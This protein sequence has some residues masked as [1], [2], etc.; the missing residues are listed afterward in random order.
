[1]YFR[2]SFDC[3]WPNIV[4]RGGNQL[5]AHEW[6]YLASDNSVHACCCWVSLYRQPNK[7]W[8]NAIWVVTVTRFRCLNEWLCVSKIKLVLFFSLLTVT[9]AHLDGNDDFYLHN[10][11]HNCLN[12][13]QMLCDNATEKIYYQCAGCVAC[14]WWKM[15]LF[16]FEHHMQN[17]YVNCIEFYPP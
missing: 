9:R 17:K 7:F 3:K 5:V 4:N 1:M 11:L 14:L 6:I 15:R 13:F 8:L 12:P 2:F 16:A 10:N